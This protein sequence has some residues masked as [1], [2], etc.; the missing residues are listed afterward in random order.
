MKLLALDAAAGACSAALWRDG[1]VVAHRHSVRARGHAEVLVP[2][3][4]AVMGEARIAYAE[5]DG[6][7]VTRGPGTFTGIRIGL[8]CARGLALAAHLPLVGLTTLEVLAAGVPD[9]FSGRVVLAALEARRGEVYA[10]A[11]GPGL[12]PLSAPAALLPE[13][14]LALVV[15]RDTA[16]VGD[17]APR[18][19]RLLGRPDLIVPGDGQPDARVLAR[20]AA[21]R[22]LPAPGVPVAPLYL[23]PPDA[24]TLSESTRS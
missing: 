24:R 11:F 14:A 6:F 9:A 5:L 7:A 20:L 4:E 13:A 1:A 15:G 12:V 10:Q 3:V 17:A 16:L 23:R 19:A 21:A 22:P 8:A 18:L 2:M